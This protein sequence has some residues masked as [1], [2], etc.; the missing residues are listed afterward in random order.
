M[1]SK[2]EKVIEE[3]SINVYR[4]TY[5]HELGASI[6]KTGHNLEGIENEILMTEI[7]MYTEIDQ[8]IKAHNK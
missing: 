4:I 7:K 1:N 8:K 6:E 2:V 3:V 5:I